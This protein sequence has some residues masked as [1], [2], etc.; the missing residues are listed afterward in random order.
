MHPA[1]FK[2]PKNALHAF[3]QTCSVDRG[4]RILS[5]DSTE[6]PSSAVIMSTAEEGSSVESH[7]RILPP[8][9]TAEELR[10]NLLPWVT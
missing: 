9:S 3:L 5:W 10:K 6:E 4:G 8:L 7:G 1:N 2:I